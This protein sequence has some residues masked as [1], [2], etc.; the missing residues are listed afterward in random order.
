MVAGSQVNAPRPFAVHPVRSQEDVRLLILVCI[1]VALVPLL[2]AEISDFVPL[3]FP[4]E[5]GHLPLL[6]GE[7]G[8]SV[9]RSGGHRA[10]G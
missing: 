5:A 7:R 4:V 3:F 9:W 8:T 1:G 10:R 6:Y 2:F